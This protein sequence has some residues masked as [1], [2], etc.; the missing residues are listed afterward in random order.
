M[1]RP[2]RIVIP[3][4]PH[5]VTQRGNLRQTVFFSNDDRR[6]YLN[7]LKR[8]FR[9]HEVTLLGYAL[10]TNHCHLGPIPPS[11]EALSNAVGRLNQDFARWQ[12]LR[13]GR[14]GHLWQNR[15]FS[16][17]VYDVWEVLAYIE[18]NP[19]RAGLVKSAWDWEWSSAKAHVT[20]VDE[21]GMLDMSYWSRCFDGPSWQKYLE[22]A[23]ARKRLHEEIR[24]ATLSGRFWG[25]DE[26]A[27]QLELQCGRSI[28]R[29]PRGRPIRRL[30]KMVKM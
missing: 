17:P 9:A 18:L 26:I 24:A 23:M 15:F 1:T 25:P 12:N 11:A 28:R 20:G 4:W 7:L 30:Q 5:H 16:C 2:A 19:V 21:T 13:C 27:E 22:A 6:V 3:G 14:T 29:R 10:M 8:H